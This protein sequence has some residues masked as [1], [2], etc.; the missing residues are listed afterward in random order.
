[1]SDTDLV[2]EVLAEFRRVRGSPFKIANNLGLSV[3]TVWAILDANPDAAV[4]TIER[5]D[6][7]GRPDLREFFVAKARCADKWD[8]NDDGVQ[9]A[10]DRFCAGTH[11]MATHRD[12]SVK[13]LCSIPL[14]RRLPPQ[15][16]YFKPEIQL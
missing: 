5:W 13:F 3:A 12:G 6:G 2:A 8:E 14:K 15:P 9:L 1:L 4:Q 10:R 11:T 16:D 7:E